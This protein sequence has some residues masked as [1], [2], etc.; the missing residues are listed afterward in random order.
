M[1]GIL[2]L[3][4]T[5]PKLPVPLLSSTVNQ[6]LAAL[7]PLLTAEEYSEIL[8]EAS[9]FMFN[10]VINLIQ[11]HLEAASENEQVQCYLNAVNGALYPG[12]YGDLRGDT[13]PRNPYLVLEED[14][15]AMTINPPNQAQRAA[16]LVNSSLKFMV[17]MRNGTL[18]PDYTPKS[19]K[20]LT[21][22]CY[23][24]LFGTT[25][26]PSLTDTGRHT[27]TIKKYNHINDSRHVLFI[28][29]NQFYTLEVL[30]ECCDV[31]A[32][33]KHQL[34]FN[35][36]ELAQ[37]IQSIIDDALA[38]DRVDSVSNG[39]GS[40][41]T[42]TYHHWKSARLELENSNKEAL[43]AI[44]NALMVVLLDTVNSPVS[45]QDKTMVISHGTSQLL[46][47]T[48]IQ[49]GS[50]TSR[51]YDKLQMIITKN[52]VA[53]VVWESS[54]MD[55]TAILRF[56]SDIFTD[57]ILKL[58]R[59]INGAE[60][61]LFDPN[62]TFASGRE[63]KPD[64]KALI[65]NKTPELINLVHLSETRLADLINQ[66]E[67]KTLTMKLDSHLISKFNI[68]ADSF[69]QVGFQIAN[70]ALYGRIANTLEPITTRK[71]RDARTE[72]IAV[73]NDLIAN[74]VKTYITSSEDSR[75]W[76]GFKACC[77]LHTTQYRD[78]MAG[79]GFE[80]HFTAL[81]HVLL[82]PDASNNLNKVN[83]YLGLE[84]IP[85]PEELAK[86][87]IPFI[88][89]ELIEKITG[90]ELL[91]SNCGNPALRLFGIPPALDQGFGI[92]YIIHKDKVVVTVS[93]KY[94]Q[95]ERFLSTFK[96]V[97]SNIKH[98][99]REKSDILV[100]AADSDARK[101]ELKKLRIEKELKNI[102]KHLSSTRH[103]I[104][105]TMSATPLS[106]HISLLGK[107][108]SEANSDDNKEDDFNY[109]GGY[110]YF[111]VGEVD[112]RSDEISR[113]QSFMNSHSNLASGLTS[114]TESRHHSS[115]NLH[116][117]ARHAEPQSLDLKHKLSLSE[118]IRD[119]LSP[120]LNALSTSL[121]QVSTAE[122]PEKQK[123]QIGRELY[124]QKF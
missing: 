45:D 67:Y 74:L 10:D 29:N 110:G 103:P 99:V 22:N 32:S 92:G 118:R 62:I 16:S 42:Q 39:I 109:L 27:V 61:T 24:N 19:G 48:N 120:S 20:L 81:V 33:C 5:V 96:S 25:R 83:K 70:Y 75:K 47:G 114:R 106:A 49:I 31:S 123:S 26:I 30:T 28:C 100:Q 63:S 66:H 65:F 119:K 17:S 53:G 37:T 68:L 124:V 38:V 87:S 85:P 108:D 111:D 102:N 76:N 56:I 21:M 40:I 113:N 55:S 52:A 59:N 50:C 8:E 11:E 84:P 15:Y 116:A 6:I 34:W 43:A 69:L 79:K 101:A 44:D 41:T 71:F 107:P 94:R 73:Q 2:K 1:D 122:R 82:R 23:W 104:D 86:I 97:I 89:N 36:A 9:Q 115:I 77:D 105:I 95:T 51:W 117:L 90:A 46:E 4:H 121:D 35:D 3:E 80:R 57:L 98:I 64:H 58:A 78:A 72:L 60:N 7:K 14:P 13:L 112:I 18:K 12:V 54:S 91:I 93:S 88:S